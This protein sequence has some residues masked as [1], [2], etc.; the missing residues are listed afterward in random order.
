MGST[1]HSTPQRFAEQLRAYLWSQIEPLGA[2]KSGR[3]LEAHTDSARKKDYWAKI[4]SG[5]A[6]MTSNDIEVLALMLFDQSPYD[7]IRAVRAWSVP[8]GD[9][10]EGR[11]DVRPVTED[12]R[13]VAKSKSRDRGG[14]D[15]QG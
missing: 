6:A 3:W 2:D 9:L 14:D 4:T 8:A 10:I 15:G 13:R 12:E 1:S 11:F 7:F 5:T